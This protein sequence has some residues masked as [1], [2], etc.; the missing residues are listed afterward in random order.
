MAATIRRAGSADAAAIAAA[1]NQGIE[2][3]ESTFETQPY[4]PEDFAPALADAGGPPFLVAQDGER[5]VGWARITRYSARE[6]YAGVGEVS[7]YLDRDARGQGLGRRL[8]DALAQEA[9]QSGYWKL[10]GFIFPT[11]ERSAGL[12]RAAGWRDVGVL[13]NHGS[14]HGEWRDVAIV[15]LS[16][17]EST[18]D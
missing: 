13:R 11:N 16:L 6:V 3:G 9:A 5:V 2:E 1:Y 14:M 7:L 8:L 4:R 18:N 17:G 15:E 10:M 12:F